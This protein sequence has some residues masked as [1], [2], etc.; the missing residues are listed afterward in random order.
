MSLGVAALLDIGASNPG[1][2][3][4]LITT[5]ILS[6]LLISRSPFSEAD[7]KALDEASAELGFATTILPG[8]RAEHAWLRDLVAA[9][10]LELASP[11]EVTYLGVTPAPLLGKERQSLWRPHAGRPWKGKLLCC[12]PL[13]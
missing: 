4:A 12:E 2:H 3:V 1:D 6:T 10:S 7:I 13:A 5:D 11:G 8:R 9:N